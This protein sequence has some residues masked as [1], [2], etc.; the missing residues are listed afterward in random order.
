VIVVLSLFLFRAFYHL[1]FTSI[2]SATCVSTY[3]AT[4]GRP[5]VDNNETCK[6]SCGKRKRN[7]N[8]LIMFLKSSNDP[9]S[10]E[11]GAALIQI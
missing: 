11:Y 7:S 8:A 4:P 3:P 10:S 6:C 9:K 1:Y 2:A 5:R